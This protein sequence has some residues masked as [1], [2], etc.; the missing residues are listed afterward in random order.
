MHERAIEGLVES[1]SKIDSAITET[2][3]LLSAL[4]GVEAPEFQGAGI[5]AKFRLIQLESDKAAVQGSIAEIRANMKR[6]KADG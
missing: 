4:K 5:Q 2:R 6:L 3:K 1:A